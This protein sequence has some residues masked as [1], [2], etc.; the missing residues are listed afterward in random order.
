VPFAA[1]TP[2]V[3]RL[4]RGGVLRAMH[5]SSH[6]AKSPQFNG[7]LPNDPRYRIFL[8]ATVPATK[9]VPHPLEIPRDRA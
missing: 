9:N 1:V 4:F 3:A 8:S 6:T 2:A 7:P 5:N